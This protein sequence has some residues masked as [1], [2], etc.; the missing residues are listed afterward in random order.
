[1]VVTFKDDGQ[2]KARLVVQGCTDQRLGKMPTSSSNRMPSISSDLPDT[3]CV[4]CFSHSQKRREMYV[5]QGDLD[6][7]PVDDNDDDDFQLESV[8]PVSDTFFEPVPE[9]VRLL[10]AVYRFGEHS[11]KMYHRV[12]T[13]LR[14]HGKRRI[15]CGTLGCGLSETKVVPSKPCFWCMLMTSCW[16]AVTLHLE[17]VSLMAVNNS[18][19]W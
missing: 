15:Y 8:Q 4:T 3:C 16:R 1:M 12:A 5:L 13:D 17:N 2:V 7:Q 18:Y 19:E 6:E 11:K 9:C 14:K 10:K